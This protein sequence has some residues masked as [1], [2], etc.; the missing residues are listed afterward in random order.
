MVQMVV[1]NKIMKLQNGKFN[2]G[3]EVTNQEI[4]DALK[5]VVDAN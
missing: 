1:D 4:I 3:G 2:P 5:M